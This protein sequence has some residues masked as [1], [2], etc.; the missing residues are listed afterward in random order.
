ME[1]EKQFGFSQLV[2]SLFFY[3]FNAL[4]MWSSSPITRRSNKDK[5][6]NKMKMIKKKGIEGKE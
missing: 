2:F 4:S 3:Q 5:K 1:Y 6:V